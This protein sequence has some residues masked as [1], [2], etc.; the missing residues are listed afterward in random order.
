MQSP[1]V[2][3]LSDNSGNN[4][5]CG[6]RSFGYTRRGIRG[7]FVPPIR[8]KEGGVGN[9]TSRIAR[10]AGK[11]DDALDDSTQRWLVK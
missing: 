1:T 10:A 2:S 7:S 6:N 8:S 9:V 4:R 5:G 3:P 11:G